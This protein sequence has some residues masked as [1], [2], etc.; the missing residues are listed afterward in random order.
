MHEV[1]MKRNPTDYLVTPDIN[2]PNEW[3]YP[4]DHSAIKSMKDRIGRESEITTQKLADIIDGRTVVLLL[5]GG[6]IQTLEKR[7]E[8][9]A[10]FDFCFMGINRFS[11]IEKSILNKGSK[12]F[13]II[14]CM[15]EQDIPLRVNDIK[16]FLSRKKNTLLMTTLCAMTWL[17]EIER[18]RILDN[19]GDKLYLMPRLLCRPAYPISLEVII[20]ELI[21]VKVKRLILFGADGYWEPAMNGKSELEIIRWNQQKMLNTYYDAGFFK[22]ERR[23]TGVGIGTFRFNKNFKYQPEKIEIVNCSPNSHYGHIPKMSY[24]QLVGALAVGGM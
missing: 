17:S 14:F 4:I 13:D 12:S 15:S 7:I 22:G 21:K 6:S 11:A 24:D 5:N 16:L 23:A 1:S 8:D 3:T 10:H 18:N 9:F 20:D 19:Y 2:K